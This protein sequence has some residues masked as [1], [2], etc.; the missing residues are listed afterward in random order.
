MVKVLWLTIG[1]LLCFVFGGLLLAHRTGMAVTLL[2]MGLFMLVDAA[3]CERHTDAK[4][5]K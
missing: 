3:G 2:G 1:A 5:N 4:L